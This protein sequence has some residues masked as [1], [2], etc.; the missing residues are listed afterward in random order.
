MTTKA[1]TRACPVHFSGD[2][3][4]SMLF[5]VNVVSQVSFPDRVESTA[6]RSS[7]VLNADR[8]GELEQQSVP[9]DKT[10]FRLDDPKLFEAI[11]TQQ[12]PP[13]PGPRLTDNPAKPQPGASDVR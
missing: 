5:D 12:L 1:L 8:Y 13:G 6:R 4:A 9:T 3:F 7:Q 2:G 10:N 11:A